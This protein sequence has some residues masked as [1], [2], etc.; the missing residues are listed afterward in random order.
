MK[1]VYTLLSL[2]LLFACSA[3]INAQSY[4]VK[5]IGKP[6]TDISTLKEGDPILLFCYGATDASAS[7][8]QTRY[9]FAKE[10]DGKLFISRKLYDKA[11]PANENLLG[12]SASRNYVF[13]VN[14]LKN[15]GGS[16]SF[17]LK[18]PDGQY[19][20]PFAANDAQGTTGDTPAVFNA[21]TTDADSIFNLS[22][23]TEDGTAV[24]LNGQNV[25]G[26][27]GGAVDPAKLVVWNEAGGNSNYMIYKPE[28][29]KLSVVDVTMY[30]YIDGGKDTT[31]TKQ[32]ALGDVVESA[33]QWG[34]NEFV[35][36]DVTFPVTIT[37]T[38]PNEWL[39]Q[40]KVRPHITFNYQVGDAEPFN[41][42]S[43]YYATG[44]EIEFPS[45]VGLK[46]AD[47]QAASYTVG[48]ADEVVT[49]KYVADNASLPF[50]PSTLTD[51]AFGEGMHWYV[52]GMR[53]TAKP[54]TYN[55]ETGNL[56]RLAADVTAADNQLFAFVGDN[57]NGFKIYNKAAGATKFFNATDG[58]P[59]TH[60]VLTDNADGTAKDKWLLEKGTSGFVFKLIGTGGYINDYNGNS[61][62]GILGFY[63]DVNDAGSAI[64]FVSRNE[65]P[66]Q[67]T[68]VTDG[69]FAADTKWYVMSIRGN[70][71]VSLEDNGTINSKNAGFAFAEGTTNVA[72]KYLWAFSGDFISG[73]K[74]YNKAA[75]A[76][77]ALSGSET[78]GQ[79]ALTLAEN[80]TS[81]FRLSAN[82][83]GYSIILTAGTNKVANDVQGTLAFWEDANAATD[84]GSRVKFIATDDP[85]IVEI[86]FRS[87]KSY[88]RAVDVVGGW[89]A[90]DLQASGLEAAI[91]ALDITACETAVAKLEASDTIAFDPAKK[92][93]I[94][95]AYSDYVF[96]ESDRKLAMYV[97]AEG[98]IVWGELNPKSY[99]YAW[100]FVK[101]QDRNYYIVNEK[102]YFGHYTW[103]IAPKVV[104]APTAEITDSVY[105]VDNAAPF[106]I[107]KSQKRAAGFIFCHYYK[108][109]ADAKGDDSVWLNTNTGDGEQSA[110]FTTGTIG[111]YKIDDFGY[112]SAWYL[113][114]VPD[115]TLTGIGTVATDTNTDNTIYDLSGRRVQKATKGFYIIGG[116]KVLVK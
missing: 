70:Q 16:V 7:D 12:N 33:P 99:D 23:T 107:E 79:T 105:T 18:S 60:V 28:V 48:E 2:L 50:K 90:A 59:G 4:V 85:S 42:A 27:G 53:G 43:D 5:S 103:G 110:D 101:G 49:V 6:V 15:V 41:T 61:G 51:G 8:Y 62:D 68:T 19:V 104:A 54:I 77:K 35:E 17:A 106:V 108:T 72:D 25:K 1:K 94:V 10:Q 63:T 38:T 102:G 66:V 81:L 55:A 116:K 75:G 36:G 47:G 97:N 98:N 111:T 45:F 26:G 71:Y 39:L 37:A 89:T 24:Y 58:N 64:S 113:V 32:Y 114:P 115:G 91:K 3:T 40:Y 73:L 56:E 109:S 92:Y 14:N 34:H 9:A 95:N 80:S 82:G 100:S 67:L 46:L 52:M 44:T 21:V 87:Y 112:G 86:P 74:V 69:Q 57:G 13:L 84:A 22:T 76:T 29:E 88:L 20:A 83:N 31:I 65:G 30:L 93:Y 11:E 96:G 78:A